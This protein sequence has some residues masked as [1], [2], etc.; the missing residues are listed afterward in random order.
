[1]ERIETVETAGV[2]PFPTMN[3][4]AIVAG[5]TM[6]LGIGVLLCLGG[7]ALGLGATH[8]HMGEGTAKAIGMGAAVWILLTW[9][10]ALFVGGMFAS[11]F[12]GKNDTMMGAMHG[13]SVWGLSIATTVVLLVLAGHHAHRSPAGDRM[14]GAVMAKGDGLVEADLAVLHMQLERAVR[15]GSGEVQAGPAADANMPSDESGSMPT[16]G[17]QWHGR[18]GEGMR[19]VEMELVH[20]DD[21]VAKQLLIA[22]AALSDADADRILQGVRSQVDKTREDAKQAATKAAHHLAAAAAIGFLAALFSLLAAMLG[23]WVGANHVHKVYH[24]R[25]YRRLDTLS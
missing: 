15:H 1:M 9:A 19:S 6:A 7:L 8:A 4:G 22:Q 18:D 11:W 13:L 20:G 14:H 23:G 12:D 25:T 17:R 2:E 10:G 21:A 3:W 5:W 24:L 16:R